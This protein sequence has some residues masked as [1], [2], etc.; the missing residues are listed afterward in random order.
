MIKHMVAFRFREDVDEADRQA[1]L[2]ELN[3]FPGHYPTM[4]RWALGENISNRDDTFSHAFTVEFASEAELLAYLGSERHERFVRER[5]RPRIAARA[6]V[7]FEVADG[8]ADPGTAGEPP[9]G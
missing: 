8:R 3:D 7:S 1:V 2:D 6:I 5:F 4:R 9:I